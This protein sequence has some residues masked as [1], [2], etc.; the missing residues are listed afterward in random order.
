VRR[1]AWMKSAAVLMS[2]LAAGGCVT[3]DPKPAIGE[4]TPPEKVKPSRLVVTSYLPRD[5]DSNG[6]PDQIPVR[7]HL[8]EPEGGW[9]LAVWVPG[10]YRF[11]LT[12]PGGGE[13]GSKVLASWEIDPEAT[14]RL[15]RDQIGPCAMLEL[16]LLESGRTDRLEVESVDLR[17][18]FTPRDGGPAVRGV[19]SMYFGR[20]R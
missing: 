7:V 19:I 8:F 15:V 9:P 16:S 11:E 5:T 18:T 20:T 1:M 2:V 13:G 14:G 10:T 17:T 4:F 6:Y 12:P 3:D